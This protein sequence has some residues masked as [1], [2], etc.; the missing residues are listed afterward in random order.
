M[1]PKKTAAFKAPR[2]DKSEAASIAAAQPCPL[3]PVDARYHAP[4]QAANNL[5]ESTGLLPFCVGMPEPH[6]VLALPGSKGVASLYIRCCTQKTCMRAQNL[7]NGY[8][9][10]V[11][12]E[13]SLCDESSGQCFHIP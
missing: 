5:V 12:P 10:Q 8:A 13:S 6:N 11:G 2:N 1:S 9:I 7:F 3:R 4:A